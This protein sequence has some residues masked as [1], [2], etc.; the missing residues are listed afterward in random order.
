[1]N[2]PNKPKYKDGSYLSCFR[3]EKRSSSDKVT[4]K[5]ERTLEKET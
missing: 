1:M 3:Q 2:G 4:S 5:R